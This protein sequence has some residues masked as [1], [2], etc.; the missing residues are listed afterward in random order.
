MRTF[1]NFQIN[2]EKKTP[3]LDLIHSTRTKLMSKQIVRNAQLTV[4]RK[5][6]RR[7]GLSVV[8]QVFENMAR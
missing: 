1:D 5:Y 2:F 6:P 4:T 8:Y 7:T 3:K